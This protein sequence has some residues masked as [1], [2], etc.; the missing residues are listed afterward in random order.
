LNYEELLEKAYSELPDVVKEHHRFE[1]PEIYSIIQGKAT[2]VQNLGEVSKAINRDPD[3]LAKFL[4]KEFGTSG[5]HDGQHLVMKGQFRKEQ[6]QERFE[7]FLNEY[8]L[9]GECGR[10][11]TKIAREGRVSFLKCEACGARQP[12]GVLK[13]TPKREENKNPEVGD[14][15]TI[16]ITRTGKKGDGMARMGGY[17]VFVS[18]AKIGQKVKAR[19][20]G[21]Q[22]STLFAS[23]IEVLN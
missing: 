3:M 21:V 6:I 12:L 11:D 4:L 19:I 23:V 14:E 2:V 7:A 20:T 15:I 9:C 10:P 13:T 1:K 16:E 18:G 22:G 5:T 17:I 8:V